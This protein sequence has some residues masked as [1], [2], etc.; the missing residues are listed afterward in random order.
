MPCPFCGSA[1]EGEF[2][3]E[4]NIHL[5]G[6]ENIEN[7]GV[8]V[9]PKLFVCLDCGSSRFSTPQTEL[10]QLARRAARR[11]A[12]ACGKSV[13]GIGLDNRIAV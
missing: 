2:T 6:L 4:I 7:P 3:A 11:E 12:S 13:G 10:P 1:N 9:F 5:R 8:L